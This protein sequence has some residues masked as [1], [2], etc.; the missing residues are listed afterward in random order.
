MMD[1][2]PEPVDLR[3]LLLDELEERRLLQQVMARVRQRDATLPR[4]VILIS[5]GAA[6]LAATIAC[7][8]VLRGREQQPMPSPVASWVQDGRVPT[9]AELLLAYG[10]YDP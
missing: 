5:W 3:A 4:R 7:V 10:G 9:N 8:V 1:K 6:A 2:D